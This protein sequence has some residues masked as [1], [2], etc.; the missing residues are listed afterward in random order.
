VS[1]AIFLLD[2]SAL[3]RLLRD[4]AVR[5]RWGQQITA[6][7]VA[8]CPIVELE[9]LYTARSVNHRAELQNLVAAAFAWVSMPER[10]FARAADVQSVLT[11]QGQHRSAGAVDLLIAAA[12]EL[13][14]LTLVHYDRDFDQVTRASG[15][16]AVWL[17]PAGSID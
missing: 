10:V 6:G 16:A 4:E 13:N 3:V 2:T 17:A 7:L 11:Q 1:P 9:L 14:S 5:S 12:A 15:Q 8:V